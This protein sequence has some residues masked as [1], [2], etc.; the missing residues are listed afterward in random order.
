MVL[1]LSELTR[2]TCSVGNS[3]AQWDLN[4]QLMVDP[5]ARPRQQQKSKPHFKH[6]DK[7]LFY[8]LLVRTGASY[9]LLSRILFG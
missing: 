1:N 3:I 7:D 4:L 2:T 8:K 9:Q 5:L 6:G